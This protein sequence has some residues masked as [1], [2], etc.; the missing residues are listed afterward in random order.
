L[1]QA[2]TIWGF[3]SDWVNSQTKNLSKVETEKENAKNFEEKDKVIPQAEIK[4]EGK[5]SEVE[6][7]TSEEKKS[8]IYK[9]EYETTDQRNEYIQYAYEIGGID[10]VLLMECENS[11]WNQYRQSE[12]VKNWR[13]EPSYWFCMIDRDFHKNIVDDSRFRNDRKRQIDKCYELWKGWTKFY[14]P[15]RYIAKAGMKCSE[16]VKDRFTFN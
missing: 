14:W 13:R 5:K 4:R 16:Y 8:Q 6:Q 11:T 2:C 10:L 9:K 7:L 12:V 15:W 1:K 3:T